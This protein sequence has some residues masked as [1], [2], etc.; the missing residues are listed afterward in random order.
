MF[1][2]RLM[3]QMSAQSTQQLASVRD[4]M[5]GFEFLALKKYRTVKHIFPSLEY[6]KV[7]RFRLLNA[8]K[9]T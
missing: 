9:L 1:Q 7:T 3:F 8:V 5:I 6:Q 4:I 2:C